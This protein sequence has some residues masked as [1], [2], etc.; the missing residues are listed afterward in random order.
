MLEIDNASKL[1]K[2]ECWAILFDWTISLESLSYD[3]LD[4]IHFIVYGYWQ[5]H[6]SKFGLLLTLNNFR[7]TKILI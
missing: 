3:D 7:L 6:T 2:D 5:H 4:M 1:S